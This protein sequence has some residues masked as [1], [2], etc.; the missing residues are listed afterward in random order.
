M[1]LTLPSSG[2]FLKHLL[3]DSFEPGAEEAYATEALQLSTDLLELASGVTEDPTGD[4]R[5]T[6]MVTQGI[7][8]MAAAILTHRLDQDIENNVFSSERIGSFGYQKTANLVAQG[9][10]TGIGLFDLVASLLAQGVGD[11]AYNVATEDVFKRPYT[12]EDMLQQ[13]LAQADAYGR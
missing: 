4:A 1:A 6:R 10:P 5:L 7:C 11:D 8:A 12:Q 9:L 3:R 2:A 13:S